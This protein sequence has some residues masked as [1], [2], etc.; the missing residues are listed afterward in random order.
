[1]SLKVFN[2]KNEATWAEN[3]LFQYLIKEL[4]NTNL[5]IG[6]FFNVFVD[7]T[8]LDILIASEKGIFVLEYKNYSGKLFA[9]ENSDWKMLKANGKESIINKGRENVFQQL[10][11]QRFSI[12]NLIS[13]K[14]ESIFPNHSRKS[15]SI[16]H[17]G[18]Y[19]IFEMLDS[20]SELD[21]S[22]KATNWLKVLSKEYFAD[23]F[24]HQRPSNLTFSKEEIFNLA[25]VLKM[26]QAVV[27]KEDLEK[28][29]DSTCPV[30][31]YSTECHRKYLNGEIIEIDSRKIRIKSD[32]RIFNLH[33]NKNISKPVFQVTSTAENPLQSVSESQ[34]D[35]TELKI[36]TN[37]FE[38]F[39]SRNVNIPLEV[40][41]FHLKNSNEYDFEISDE[42]LIII[43]PSWLY[44][45]TS[46]ANLDF[47]ERTVLTQKFSSAPSNHHILRGM[48]VN[49]GLDDIV[50]DPAD[51]EKAKESARSYV[52]S[53]VIELIASDANAEE[54][55]EAIETEVDALGGWAEDYNLREN[56]NTEEFIISPKLGLKGKIDLVLKDDENRIV[57]I[58]ELKSST[59]DWKTGSIKEYHELQVVSYGIMVLLRQGKRFQ[60]LKGETPSVLYS[61]ATGNIQKPAK[62]DSD[63]FS[64]VFKN[65]NIL[66]NSEFSLKLPDLYPHPMTHPNGCEKCGQK[67]ICMDVCRII[68]FE[69]CDSDCF[70]HPEN[71]LIAT[72]CSLKTGIEGNIPAQFKNWIDILNDTRILNHK[73]YAGIITA[74]KSVNSL[75]GKILEFKDLPVL[76]SSSNNKYFYKHTLKSG[77]YSEFREFD[78]V[79]LSD[80]YDLEKAELNLGI[81]KKLTFNHCTIE[82]NKEL[83][84]I[85]KYVFPY[86]PDRS[87]YLNFVGLYKGFMSDEKLYKIIDKSSFK[88]VL[89]NI[90]I[91]LL[92]GVPGSGKTTTVVNKTIELAEQNKKVFVA[93][94]TNKAIDNIHN[95]LIDRDENIGEKIHR[96]G[97]T[98][99]IEDQFSESSLKSDYHDTETLK[100]EVEGKTIFLSTIHSAN[101][102]V[103]SNLSN[104]DCVIIDEASQINIPMSFVPMSL[105][106]NIQLVGDHFQLPPIFSEEIVEKSENQEPFVSIFEK[107]WNNT[108]GLMNSEE[109]KNL[110]NQY[111]MVKEIIAY[112]SLLFYSDKITTDAKVELEQKEFINS[113]NNEWESS[114]LSDVIDPNIPSVWLQVDST[115]LDSA[116][117][118][119]GEADYCNKIIIDLLKTGVNPDQIGI[120][121]PF[122]LQ[123]N[124]IKNNIYS[125]LGEENPDILD[126]IQIDTID[127]FQGS[128]KDIILI[129]LCSSDL[130]NNFLIKDLRRFNVAITR[131]R[132]KRIILGDLQSFVSTEN[133][134]NEKIAGIINDGFTKFVEDSD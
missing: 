13:G 10:R 49:T 55:D 60:D 2:N 40:N 33:Y 73:K 74:E 53:R 25:T 8:E 71:P 5:D 14:F 79:L 17:V 24:H 48:A 46:F 125:S 26:D 65:R 19:L 89:K 98:Q 102:E 100:K 51:I 99:R 80:N 31:F 88:D 22:L 113:I 57:D 86:Y 6:L 112:P 110:F 134:N 92:Q 67:N 90:N 108:E 63:I 107:I 38:Y 42:T 106:N 58:L 1:M 59:P 87:E 62:F 56:K 76:E 130:K 118:N 121:S 119:P 52:Q 43:L 11:R 35:D 68:Q 7:G 45:V 36:L 95:K 18:S 78:I 105:S 103:V 44:S 129:S 28:V 27:E 83:K 84:Y 32:D 50:E 9:S 120:I 123:V 127:R 132:F 41:F 70:K 101:S 12:M 21:V 104:Y 117:S 54:I 23:T 75:N 34:F 94:F 72:S 61:K 93:T 96:F 47:C 126:T 97:R 4:E 115:D 15:K 81:I 66:L 37:V 30:C 131:P 114:A 109:R 91:E 128:Q 77:N 29:S 3:E 116:R 82:L 124:T 133:E 39:K 85:P 20:S 64:K 16:D 69:H 111:R 122:R